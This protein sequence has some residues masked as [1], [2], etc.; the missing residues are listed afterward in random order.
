MH[1]VVCL[2]RVPD[3]TARIQPDPQGK[4]IVTQGVEFILSPY[5][6]IALERA[7]QL[8]EA[9][10][11]T[12]VTALTLGPKEATKEIRKALALGAD[13]AVHILETLD[14]RDAASTAEILAAAIEQLGADVVMC[15]WKAMDLDASSV[16]AYLAAR[17][18]FA[19]ASYVTKLD[20]EGGALVAHREV[21]GAT[22]VYVVP[23]PCV[24]TVQKGLAEP[25]FAGLKNIMAAKKKPLAEQ[26]PAAV[27]PGSEIVALTPPPARP[28]G[29]IVG[30]GVAAVPEL[31]RVLRDEVHVLG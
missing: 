26:A 24:I 7:V 1:I 14:L 29:R 22:E 21:E 8:V 20:V 5:D 13:A 31:V 17:L 25:R 15:G 18:G 4:A 19:Y 9:G 2:K 28:A 16:G 6:E 10:A 27:D 30:E 11:A 23:T 12:K 3:T